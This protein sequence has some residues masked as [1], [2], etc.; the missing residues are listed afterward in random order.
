ME[1]EYLVKP[2]IQ[3]GRKYRF[4]ADVQWFLENARES[5]SENLAILAERARLSGDYFD[6]IWARSTATAFGD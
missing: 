2:A 6:C 5:E 3:Y 4:D 1:L